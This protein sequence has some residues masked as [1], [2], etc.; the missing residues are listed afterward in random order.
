MISLAVVLLFASGGFFIAKYA[1]GYFAGKKTIAAV[2]DSGNETATNAVPL[3]D[4][5]NI[6]TTSADAGAVPAVPAASSSVQPQENP[7][8]PAVA[9]AAQGSAGVTFAVIGDTQRFTSDMGGNLQ[10]TV[11]SL[12]KRDLDAVF[13]MGDVVSSCDGKDACVAKYE[14]WKK[15]MLPI[16]NKT[17]LVMGNHDRSGGNKADL[18]WQRI[19]DLPMNGPDGFKELV[20]SLDIGDSHFVVLDSEK[21][22]EHVVN[23]EQRDWLEG[24]LAKNRKEN[25]FVFFHEPAFRVSQESKDILENEP[26]ERDAL[27]NILKKYDVTAVF[28]GHVHFTAGKVR[29]GIHQF[30]IGDTDAAADD[31]PHPEFTDFGFTGH[32]YSV[33]TVTGKNVDLKF[34]SVD[35]NMLKE[36]SFTD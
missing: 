23:K 3:A 1:Y 12:V 8:A 10:R 16:F 17:Y 19:F 20:Y 2:S 7:H 14:N 32:Y 29:D 4:K 6:V 31:T 30:I 21:P 26:D 24:D 35:G 34:Y 36:Y 27:W 22:K 28:N 9:D 5:G 18:V 15:I 13:V 11:A 33:V 25:V